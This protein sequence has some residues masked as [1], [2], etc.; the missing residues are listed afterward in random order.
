MQG[1][2]DH[3]GDNAELA[4]SDHRQIRAYLLENAADRSESGHKDADALQR[5]SYTRRPGL[6]Q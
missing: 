6:L 4:A 2:S 1:L 3:F 5:M